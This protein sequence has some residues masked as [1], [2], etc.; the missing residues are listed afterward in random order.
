MGTA[1]F[2]AS[3][4]VCYMISSLITTLEYHLHSTVH[5][6]P[7]RVRRSGS[8]TKLSPHLSGSSTSSLGAL[9]PPFTES[10]GLV[11]EKD[12][13]ISQL[14]ATLQ[15]KEREQKEM[16]ERITTLSRTVEDLQFQLEEQDVISGDKLEVA[17]EGTQLVLVEL[18]GQLV[19]EREEAARL[20]LQLQSQQVEK[21]KH[22]V[23]Q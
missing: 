18:E 19:R 12:T 9:K 5:S 22:F 6:S 21:I 11:E 14:Q 13:L 17:E 7:G 2:P 20:R 15:G 16:A 3:V 1:V 10:S 23:N 4:H 8:E